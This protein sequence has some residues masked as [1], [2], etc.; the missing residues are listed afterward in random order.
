MY[1]Y[2]STNPMVIYVEKISKNT[3]ETC[4]NSNK[5]K[6]WESYKIVEY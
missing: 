4:Q 5:K 2:A 1:F 6:H 3:K